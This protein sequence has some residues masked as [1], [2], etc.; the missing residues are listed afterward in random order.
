MHKIILIAGFEPFGGE[1]INSAWETV[2]AVNGLEVMTGHHVVI[3]MLPCVFDRAR[4]VLTDA[5]HRVQPDIVIVVGQAGGRSD[6]SLER[7]AININDARIEDN[8][9]QQPIDTPVDAAGPAAYFSTLPIKAMMLELRKQGIP[10]SISNT[11]GTFVCNHIFYSMMHSLRERPE[12]RAGF[13][14]MPY[15]PQQAARFPGAPSMSGEQMATA[16]LIATQAAITT[17]FDLPVPAGALH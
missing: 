2:K 14:H 11:A 9:G 17:K 16:L 8:S 4:H 12:V 5:I 1:A 3:K 15:L 7:I 10:A 6:I 13:I